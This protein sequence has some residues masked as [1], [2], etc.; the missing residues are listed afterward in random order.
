MRHCDT[1]Y[2]SGQFSHRGAQF[3]APAPAGTND[4]ITDFSAMAEQ[5]RQTYANAEEVLSRF[6]ASLDNDALAPQPLPISVVRHRGLVPLT[7]VNR[8]CRVG[9]DWVKGGAR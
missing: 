5:M 1:I 8:K 9:G 2:A 3:H 7:L 6:E 4:A